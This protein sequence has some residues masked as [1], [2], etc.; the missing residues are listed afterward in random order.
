M[1]KLYQ[2]VKSSY[3]KAY[4]LTNEDNSNFLYLTL[5]INADNAK[6]KQYNFYTK[7]LTLCVILY[8]K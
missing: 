3:K 1:Y 7:T 2:L 6:K 8:Y 4:I 5:T